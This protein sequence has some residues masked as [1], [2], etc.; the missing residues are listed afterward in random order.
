MLND[1]SS[2]NEFMELEVKAPLSRD[3]VSICRIEMQLDDV[4]R[5]ALA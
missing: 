1:E 2:K 3:H 5:E 4:E